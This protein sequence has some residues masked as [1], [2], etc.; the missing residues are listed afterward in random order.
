MPTGRP[1]SAR[2]E[3]TPDSPALHVRA[4]D[5]LRYIRRTMENAAAFTAISGWGE[6]VIGLTAVGA[7]WL[8]SRTR[9]GDDW[10]ATWLG[11]AAVALLIGG[12]A[13]GMKVREA[14][15]PLLTGP[16]RKFVL[17]FAP[18]VVVGALLTLAFAR[19]ELHGYL[20]GI[21]LLLYGTG[22]VTGGAFSVRI[23][24]VMGLAFMALGA[25]ALLG[26]PSWGN[27]LLVAGFGGV[28]ILFGLLIARRHGG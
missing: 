9:S 2:E 14:R 23:V 12:V 26:A 6:L 20:P 13:T 24:P 10:L 16:V 25:V 19:A 21:W 17:A 28:H 1:L 7:G 8:A 22:V 15:L 27:A 18:P 4:M 11:E 5:D 3:H